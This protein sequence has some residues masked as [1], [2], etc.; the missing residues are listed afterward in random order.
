MATK[1]R[2]KPSADGILDAA[3]KIF[4]AQGYGETSLRDLM[5][6]AGVSTTAFYARFDS[7]EAVLDELIRRMVESLSTEFLEATSKAANIE[8]GFAAAV[9][10]MM[11]SL[12]PH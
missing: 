10:V 7:K 4:A 1:R 12:V 11:T 3:E 9:D 6:A 5:A 2:K 8:A